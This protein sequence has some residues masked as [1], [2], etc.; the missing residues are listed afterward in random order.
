MP[1][2]KSIWLVAI[3]VACGANDEEVASLADLVATCQGLC[4]HDER[5]LPGPRYNLAECQARCDQAAN[6][7]AHF[8]RA[9][10]AALASCEQDA[11]CI[12][13]C[14]VKSADR[15]PAI[16]RDVDRC[17]AFLRACGPDRLDG[18]F[19]GTFSLLTTKARE[20]IAACF[21]YDCR[22]EMFSTCL[23]AAG[24]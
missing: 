11:A 5:C 23:T 21:S 8:S 18:G 20:A 4:Q 16:R 19:C 14:D 15:E 17:V 9:A 2:K 3:M 6:L 12:A 1:L 7:P 24:S 10:L 13:D 22:S